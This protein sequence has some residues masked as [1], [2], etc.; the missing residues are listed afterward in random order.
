LTENL[1]AVSPAKQK[2]WGGRRYWPA[3]EKWLELT[4]KWLELTD[5]LAKLNTNGAADR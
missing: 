1:A 3:V 5:G 2:L 4:E